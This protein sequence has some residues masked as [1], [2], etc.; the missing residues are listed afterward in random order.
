MAL[1][2]DIFK[3]VE[4]LDP[5]LTPV[6]RAEGQ[7]DEQYRES[8]HRQALASSEQLARIGVAGHVSVAY[9]DTVTPDEIAAHRAEFQASGLTPADFPT[10]RE[11]LADI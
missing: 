8:A 2:Y 9:L 3:Q 7:T 5:K 6:R 1:E 10:T 11:V 4:G